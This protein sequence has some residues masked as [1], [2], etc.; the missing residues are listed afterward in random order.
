MLLREFTYFNKE[1][2]D[3]T[4]DLRYDIDH[5]V[6]PIESSDLRKCRLTLKMINSLR[7]ANEARE[8]EQEENLSLIKKMYA[9]PT[10]STM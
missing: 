4:D 7:K 2:P 9:T 1:D 5:D 6:S 8:K 10:D 3:L